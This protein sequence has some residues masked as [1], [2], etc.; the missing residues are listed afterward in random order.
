MGILSKFSGKK[1]RVPAK[2]SSAPKAVKGEK[3]VVEV[4]ASSDKDEAKAKNQDKVVARGP[5]AREHGGNAH[6]I[7]I[8]PLATEKTTMLQMDNQYTFVVA[9]SATKVD[10]A[11][12]VRDLYGVKPTKVRIVNLEGK[13]VR[14]GRSQGREKNVKKAVVSLKQ[15]DTISAT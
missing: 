15:G 6:R 3:D 10:V 8:R 5:L 12:A 2:K 1:E 4:A 14:S 7:L 13:S 11:H 9:N